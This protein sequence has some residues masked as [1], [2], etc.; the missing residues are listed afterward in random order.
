MNLSTRYSDPELEKI[1]EQG[2]IYMCA[3]PAQVAE[4]LNML[5]KLHRYQMNC[6][7]SPTNDAR[8]HGAIAQHVELA[9]AALE[10]CLDKVVELEKWDRETLTMPNCLR[11]RQM[12]E[13]A[14]GD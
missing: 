7:E 2:L 10:D 9:H 3:C 13:I 5:R 4:A 12:R 14:A 6:L 8:V 1:V 11:T